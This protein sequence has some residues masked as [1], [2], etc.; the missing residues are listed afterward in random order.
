MLYKELTPDKAK[1][2]YKKI[3]IFSLDEESLGTLDIITDLQLLHPTFRFYLG[4]SPL[5]RG[6]GDIGMFIAGKLLGDFAD[7]RLIAGSSVDPEVMQTIEKMI[8]RK[9]L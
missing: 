8:E 3:E 1:S 2:R 7:P 4:T 6:S 9:T 5:G